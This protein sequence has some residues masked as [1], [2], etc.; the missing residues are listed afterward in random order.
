MNGTR[1][2]TGH[3]KANAAMTRTGRCRWCLLP[4]ATSM[5][6]C[7]DAGTSLS[8]VDRR[9]PQASPSG[10]DSHTSTGARAGDDGGDAASADVD[11]DPEDTG[12]ARAVSAAASSSRRATKPARASESRGRRRVP[13]DAAVC[14][15]ATSRPASVAPSSS[16]AL[17]LRR[18]LTPTMGLLRPRLPAPAAL[19]CSGEAAPVALLPPPSPA[20]TTDAPAP[21]AGEPAPAA[22]G[23]A[24]PARA[25]ISA[26]TFSLNVFQRFCTLA[27]SS[28]SRARAARYFSDSGVASCGSKS[29]AASKAATL[30]L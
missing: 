19:V 20:A 15:A 26:A 7:T 21:P 11:D 23:D 28:V 4:K 25:V 10:S 1:R 27:L 13:A 17:C 2:S 9:V 16:S 24:L 18:R 12:A 3:V 8:T 29:F 14:A 6:A 5:A 30:A 22:A